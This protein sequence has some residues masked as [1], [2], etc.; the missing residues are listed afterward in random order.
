M[1]DPFKTAALSQVTHATLALKNTIEPPLKGD[2]SAGAAW[3]DDLVMLLEQLC[4]AK[5]DARNY[6]ATD[7]D[8][9]HAVAEGL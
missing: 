5:R 3:Q 6:G 7:T 9:N 4:D 8:I 2:G 1:S